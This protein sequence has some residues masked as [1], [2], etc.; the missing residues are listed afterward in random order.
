EAGIQESDERDILYEIRRRDGRDHPC[1]YPCSADRARDPYIPLPALQ[2]SVRLDEGDITGRRLS[3]RLEILLWIQPLLISAVAVAVFRP[4]F[5]LRALAGRH[6][7]VPAAE[8]H[9][10]R[11]HQARDRIAR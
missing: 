2:H 9:L 3:V 8:R 10:D 6:C 11:F 5:R 1:R 7:R 4:C